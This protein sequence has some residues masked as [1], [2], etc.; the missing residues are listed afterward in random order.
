MTTNYAKRFDAH[1]L[2]QYKGQGGKTGLIHDLYAAGGP[3]EHAVSGSFLVYTSDIR[4]YLKR[5]GYTD[6]YI[7]RYQSKY[8]RDWSG[9]DALYFDNVAD[10]LVRLARA[11]PNIGRY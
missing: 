1:I 2:N 9:P 3:W 5:I 10:A 8:K 11:N 4:R 6:A 7:D